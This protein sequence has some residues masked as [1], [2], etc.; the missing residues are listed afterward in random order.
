MP[1]KVEL[2]R[3]SNLNN[4]KLIWPDPLLATSAAGEKTYFYENH[5]KVPLLVEAR[6][7]TKDIEL[8]FEIEYVLCS[9]QCELKQ[10]HL[11]VVIIP[12]DLKNNLQLASVFDAFWIMP[13]LL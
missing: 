13:E 11:S 5:L 12:E 7:P 2:K 8:E 1:T 3:S 4:Y 9:N 6:N 10:E